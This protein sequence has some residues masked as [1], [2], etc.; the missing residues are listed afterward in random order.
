MS[1]IHKITFDCEVLT[2]MF[3]G[4]ADSNKPELRVST[5]RGGMRYWYRALLGGRGIIKSGVLAEEEEK[6]FGS[7]EKGSSVSLMLTT[8]SVSTDTVKGAQYT[9]DNRGKP[10]ATGIAYLWYS[11]TLGNTNDKVGIKPG[12]A[13]TVTLRGRSKETLLEAVDALKLLAAFGGL[14]SRARRAAGSFKIEAIQSSFE[15][16]AEAADPEFCPHM[17]SGHLP[18][19]PEFNV[20][21]Q[22]Y[23]ETHKLPE[24]FKRWE[25]AVEFVGKQMKSY[26]SKRGA[27][28]NGDYDQVKN[29]LQNNITPAKIDRANFGLPLGFQYRSLKG[30]VARNRTNIDLT[31]RNGE[32][33][34]ASP[35]LFSVGKSN[36]GYF[37]NVIYFKSKFLPDGGQIKIGRSTTRLGDS[38]IITNFIAELKK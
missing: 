29:Q 24:H 6:V 35:I 36:E 12:E 2:P 30:K 32:N 3:L 4:G 17:L 20:Y 10:A 26:R 15:L 7:S 18:K 28:E 22:N 33:R 21:N 14:G 1:R 19:Q 16:T 34:K 11:L 37:I 27:G 23:C 38:S 25:E 9:L 8:R 31:G 13:F 5:I